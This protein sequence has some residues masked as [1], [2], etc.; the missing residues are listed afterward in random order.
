MK[1]GAKRIKYTVPAL[2]FALIRLSQDIF[3]NL[4]NNAYQQQIEEVKGEDE[5][6]EPLPQNKVS[7]KKIFTN[8]TELIQLLTPH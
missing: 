8:I 3:H 1:G 5:D 2:V 6:E 7:Q 4:Y